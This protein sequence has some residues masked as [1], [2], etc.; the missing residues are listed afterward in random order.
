MKN[1]KE[2]QKTMF[3]FKE[4]MIM[5]IKA[6][7]RQNSHCRLSRHLL[8]SF[9]GAFLSVSLFTTLLCFTQCKNDNKSSGSSSS[10][11]AC[12]FSEKAS[13]FSEGDGT[14][15]SPYVIY[16]CPDLALISDDLSAHY[17]LGGN[18]NASGGDWTPIGES[19]SIAF[20]GSLDGDGYLIR[21][22]T[23][24]IS[25]ASGTSRV[26]FFGNVGLGAVI[27]NIALP[28]VSIALDGRAGFFYVG[29]L[30]GESYGTISN[31]Y[32]TGTVTLTL[33]SG[34]GNSRLGGLVGYN[35][36]GGTINNS[37]ARVNV[38]A[39]A[40][41]NSVLGGLAGRSD[42]TISNSY[43]TGTAACTEAGSCS[44][45]S[46]G[47]LVGNHSG[48]TIS[49]SYWDIDSTQHTAG[50]GSTSGMYCSDASN[51]GLRTA[52]MKAVTTDPMTSPFGLDVGFQFSA[53]SYPKLKLCE[54]DPTTN[55]CR[56]GSFS[57]ELL[58]GQE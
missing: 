7:K 20:T 14:V 35:A 56:S 34:L 8:N 44:S 16:T 54:I 58:P 12:S 21:N 38:L 28:D 18:I 48:G 51:V 42:G 15:D 53:G 24:D 17:K 2:T 52:Q 36:G 57:T 32:A 47:G 19:F 30:V 6:N 39:R 26:G 10:A 25:Q 11:P 4:K 27:S 41:Q 31:S 40:R 45:S 33:S 49:D 13:A 37:Y 1:M 23:V 22:L 29:G 5:N 3:N 50:C 55:G 43:A 9:F 46:L